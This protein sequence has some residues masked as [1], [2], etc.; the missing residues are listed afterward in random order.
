MVNYFYG[1]FYITSNVV[2][3]Y[4]YVFAQIPFDFRDLRCLELPL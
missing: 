3:Y 4:M 1:S 2:K